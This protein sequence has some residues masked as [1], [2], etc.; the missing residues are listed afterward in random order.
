[1][2]VSKED[3]MDA[4]EGEFPVISSGGRG[5]LYFLEVGSRRVK[6]VMLKDDFGTPEILF[7]EERPPLHGGPVR[8]VYL[9]PGPF[10]VGKDAGGLA[11]AGVSFQAPGIMV[12]H[13]MDYAGGGDEEV[14]ALGGPGAESDG[15]PKVD[16]SVNTGFFYVA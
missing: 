9:R 10:K 4:R 7:D 15:I 13:E 16:N 14:E 11:R 8:R 5:P 12:A 3:G 6:G 1:M 2:V